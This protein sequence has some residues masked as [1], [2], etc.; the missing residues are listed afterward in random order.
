MHDTCLSNYATGFTVALTSGLNCTKLWKQK[1]K[2]YIIFIPLAH[3]CG[4]INSQF[5][6]L[7]HYKKDILWQASFLDKVPKIGT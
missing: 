6:K 5:S 3:I 1:M 4:N 2:K 7:A